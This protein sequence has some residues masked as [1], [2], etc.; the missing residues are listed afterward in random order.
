MKIYNE[1]MTDYEYFGGDYPN[2]VLLDDAKRRFEIQKTSLEGRDA[3]VDGVEERIVAQ[4]HTNPLNQSKYDKKLSFNI[5]SNVHTG[6]IIEF[7]NKIWLVVSKIFDKQAYKVGSVLECINTLNLHQNGILYQIPYVVFDNIA[8]TRMG[9]DTNTYFSTPN[10]KMMIMV[11]DDSITRQ[12]QRS[13][14]F[15][16]YDIDGIQD[17]YEVIDV[18]RVRNSGLIIFEMAWASDK[19]TLPNYSIQITNGT[20]IQLT[21]TQTIQ[22]NVQVYKDNVLLSPTPSEIVYNSSDESIITVSNT[23]EVQAIFE[24]DAKITVSYGNVSTSININVSNIAQDNFTYEI[25]GED[26]IVKNYSK[27]YIA[28]KY[29]NGVLVQ[30]TEF[31]F[32]IIAD[33]VPEN[34]YTLTIISDTECSIKANANTYYITLRAMDRIDNT[35]YS[36]KIIKLRNIF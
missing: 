3:I 27:N 7:D 13:D 6:S 25:V 36:D 24:G 30:D 31:D 5:D 9:Y 23:G 28:N 35:Q 1:W 15:M 18:N 16:L 20:D 32:S 2:N 26:S 19:Q 4:N 11:A 12:I 22:L 29:N 14:I 21:L 8:L 34:A 17:N 10:S 33:D